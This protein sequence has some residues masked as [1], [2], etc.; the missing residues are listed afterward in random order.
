MLRLFAK[1]TLGHP[2]AERFPSVTFI[3]PN[4]SDIPPGNDD[5]PPSDI[6]DG[7]VLV[8]RVYDALQKNG[9]WSKT[10]L[11]IVYDEHGGF[12]DHVESRAV[13][14]PASPDYVT[15]M[16]WD[17]DAPSGPDHIV[18]FR[19]VRVP[20]FVVSPLVEPQTVS[21]A[22]FD[23]TSIL[24]TIAMRFLRAAPPSLGERYARAN[25]LGSLL[26]RS[27]PRPSLP[28]PSLPAPNRLPTG[29]THLPGDFHAL[30]GNFR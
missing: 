7:Q 23:H 4:I 11:V 29:I 16:F 27:S 9:L 8:K 15:P 25:D 26:T 21:H 6:A 5:A 10:L 3:D 19:G 20:A 30:I 17:P 24:K 18:N 2:K 22:T 28:S 12:F 1:Y 14:D 13:R